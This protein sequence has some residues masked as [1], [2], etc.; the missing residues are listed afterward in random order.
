MA[1]LA[2]GGGDAEDLGGSEGM[3]ELA[4][5][6]GLEVGGG[7]EAEGVVGDGGCVEGVVVGGVVVVVGDYGV[8]GGIIG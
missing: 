7:W 5:L 1:V 4:V 2:G 8:C 3:A 6:D